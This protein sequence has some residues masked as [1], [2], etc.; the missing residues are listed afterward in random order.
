L[1]DE[2]QKSWYLCGVFGPCLRS[3]MQV[4]GDRVVQRLQ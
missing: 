1:P 3:G 4:A 2:L